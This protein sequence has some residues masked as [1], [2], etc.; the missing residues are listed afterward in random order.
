MDGEKIIVG[1]IVVIS[2]DQSSSSNEIEE[3]DDIDGNK[4]KENFDMDIFLVIVV[5]MRN[6]NVDV[7]YLNLIIRDNK[8]FIFE[9]VVIEEIIDNEM[10]VIESVQNVQVT[11]SD[12]IKEYDKVKELNIYVGEFKEEGTM[13]EVID[14]FVRIIRMF[15]NVRERFVSISF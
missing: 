11:R 12:N 1:F 4:I 10:Y 6:E 8:K 5:D 9:L 13:E 14:N 2:R 3:I 7:F 15:R